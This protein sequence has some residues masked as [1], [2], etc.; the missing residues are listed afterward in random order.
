MYLERSAEMPVIVDELENPVEP[1]RPAPDSMPEK[2]GPAPLFGVYPALV[3]NVADPE[4][5]GRVEVSLPWAVDPDEGP[6]QIWARMATLMAGQGRGTWFMPDVGDEVLVAFE[7]GNVRRPYIVGALWNGAD[8]PPVSMDGAGEN[9]LKVIH[10]RAGVKI[11]LDDTSG[12]ARLICETPSG[13]RIMLED[14]TRT[15]TIED[16]SGSQI[17]LANGR[18]TVNASMVTVNAAMVEVNSGMARFSGVVQCDTLIANS[19]VSASYTPGA[20]NIW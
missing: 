13:Q 6:L 20:G 15:V 12:D 5:Q 7:A 9:N 16:G 3:Q 8:T 1:G 10:S 11:T 19:V 4:G 17:Q 2:R 14:N 18:V